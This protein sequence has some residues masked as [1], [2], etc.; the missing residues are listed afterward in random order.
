MADHDAIMFK[1][2][3][4]CFFFLFGSMLTVMILMIIGKRRFDEVAGGFH[5]MISNWETN[6]VESVELV[7]SLGTCSAGFEKQMVTAWVGT[8][9]GCDCLGIY[10]SR[11]GVRSG[12]SKGGCNYNETICG[13]DDIYSRP[14]TVLNSWMGQADLCV[15]RAEGL[16][17]RQLRTNMEED[18]TCKSGFQKCGNVDGISKGI[19]IPD[20][21][22]CP[23]TKFA[24]STSNPDSG[25][26]DLQ[27]TGTGNN[28]YYSRQSTIHPVVEFKAA[29]AKACLNP[30]DLSHTPGRRGYVL[31]SESPKPGCIE[32]IRYVTHPETQVGELSLFNQNNVPHYGLPRYNVNDKFKYFKFSRHL[33]EWDPKCTIL[34]EDLF[35]L[36]ADVREFQKRIKTLVVLTILGV[37]FYGLVGFAELAAV[38]E[39]NYVYKI[40]AS[41]CRNVWMLIITIL[42]IIKM[43]KAKHTEGVFLSIGNKKCSDDFTNN[44]FL[45]FED[46]LAL[47][48]FKYP[49]I[50][51]ILYAVAAVFEIL[52]NALC[53]CEK[54]TVKPVVYKYG[55]LNKPAPTPATKPTPTPALAKP[56]AT[57]V[58]NPYSFEKQNNVIVP[59]TDT[60]SM[61]STQLKN[62][63]GRAPPPPV[64]VQPVIYQPVAVQPVAVQP[65]AVNGAIHPSN[66]RPAA[67]QP[68][69]AKPVDSK[70]SGIPKPKR[71]RAKKFRSRI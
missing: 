54:N 53:H 50:S 32:D 71:P 43:V 25:E 70:P 44:F 49:L 11:D 12:M 19:C 56:K 7:N 36:Q 66:T 30:D 5:G 24:L 23:I 29:E 57:N 51:I 34:V 68:P 65:V 52:L 20:D 33:I 35:T 46:D 45:D 58:Y 69:M 13:C 55:A 64:I 40:P 14:K 39:K 42:L 4:L 62:R 10:C 1:E 26:F 28:V 6:F 17:F 9:H 16:N 27:E 61:E 18:G 47:Y 38:S 21:L 63:F 8:D 3:C 15:K 67:F 22:D 48:M 60:S 37:I 59:P 2:I 41:G 31:L